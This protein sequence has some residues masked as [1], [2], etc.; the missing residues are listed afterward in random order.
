LNVTKVALES[1]ALTLKDDVAHADRFVADLG[2]WRLL[3][4]KGYE[5]DAAATRLHHLYGAIEDFVGR[6]LKT[7][8]GSVP[9]GD[10]SH[11][12][13]LEAG[14][15]EV[16]GVRAVILPRL[17]SIDELRRFR[18]R[19]RKRYD[20]SLDPSLVHSVVKSTLGAWPGIRGHLLAFVAFVDECVEK[21]G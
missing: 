6:A 9:V 4:P 19:F 2:T 11:V 10:D 1:L 21:A 16:R 5:A 3:E 13:V 7:F 18:H 17:D 14:A 15:L 20:S 12:R 8:D